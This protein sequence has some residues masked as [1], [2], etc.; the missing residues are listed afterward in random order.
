MDAG[1]G[2]AVAMGFSGYQKGYLAGR[3][4]QVVTDCGVVGSMRD[5]PPLSLPRLGL[6]RCAWL[7][8]IT[9]GFVSSLAVDST[10]ATV[11]PLLSSHTLRKYAVDLTASVLQVFQVYP[12]VLIASSNGSLSLTDGSSTTTDVGPIG[13]ATS[14]EDTLMVYSFAQSYGAPFVGKC[15]TNSS[16]D[17]S[18][19]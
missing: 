9:I 7:A 8:V 11:V 4:A 10:S 1:S 12:P 2:A 3:D 14:C 18:L 5:R 13:S 15:D 17:A 16:T 19:N 6:L